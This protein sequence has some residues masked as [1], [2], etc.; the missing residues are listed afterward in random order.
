MS[1][2]LP[3][4][5][6]ACRQVT[7]RHARS[8][9]FASHTLPREKRAA[10]YAV[11]AMCRH[12]DDA[13]DLAPDAEARLQALIELRRLVESVYAP[14]ELTVPPELPWL[15]AFADTIGR[16]A[17][18]KVYFFDLLTGV[19]MDQG[20]V[21]LHNWLELRQYCYHVASVVGLMMTHIMATPEEHL[22]EP[23]IELGIAMQLTNILRDIA[24]DYGRDR[25]YLP[26][27]EME[28]YG[29][30]EDDI[31]HQ[32]VTESFRALMR[33]Q[34]GRARERYLLS[35]PGITELPRD[36]SALTVWSMRFIYAGI[37]EE[38]ERADY[39]VLDRRVYVT[40]PRKCYLAF[41]AWKQSRAA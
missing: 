20:R 11:Y 35:E 21:R 26:A 3:P 23:A 14:G 13:I 27:D 40:T 41:K 32:R 22:L 38:I 37:L 7:R 31:R 28:K 33:F 17:I 34:I 5:Y 39:H 29:V 36:G 10:A 4:A 30:S 9:Y 6:A 24:E 2:P 25:V 8:F 18:P 15:P 12:I 19:E 1:S 16:Y